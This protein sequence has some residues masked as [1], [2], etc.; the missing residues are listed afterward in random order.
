MEQS[1]ER[2]RAWWDSPDVDRVKPDD[3]AVKW[4]LDAMAKHQLG[5]RRV[6]DTMPAAT[7]RSAGVARCS[8]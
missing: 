7:Y 4:F 3:A 2:A 1:L 8:R 5:R 6:L